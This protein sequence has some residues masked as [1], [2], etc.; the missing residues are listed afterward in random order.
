MINNQRF[1]FTSK[2]KSSYSTTSGDV[3]DVTYINSIVGN[4]ESLLSQI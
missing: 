4:I 3:Y 1:I 2:V